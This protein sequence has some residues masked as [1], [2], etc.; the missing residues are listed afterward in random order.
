MVLVLLIFKRLSSNS[1]SA[2]LCRNGKKGFPNWTCAER[3]Y[4]FPRVIR[5]ET[6]LP[7]CSLR[8]LL[9]P[10]AFNVHSGRICFSLFAQ[11]IIVSA[12]R[13]SSIT[14]LGVQCCKAL[15]A[16]TTTLDFLLHLSMITMI[17]KKTELKIWYDWPENASASIW[18]LRLHFRLH[19]QLIVMC[20]IIWL[21]L[22]VDEDMKHMLF[23][24]TSLKS[25]LDNQRGEMDTWDALEE[26]T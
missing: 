10:T 18:P 2:V 4:H 24:V 5:S 8:H 23:R 17:W 22:T 9:S 3:N 14:M 12:V 7:V 16:L 6:R 15:V 21:Q 13:C 26:N 20:V 19:K 1:H 25:S 11:A